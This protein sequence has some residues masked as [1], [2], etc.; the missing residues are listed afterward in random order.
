MSAVSEGRGLGVCFQ[1]LEGVTPPRG[2]VYI[3]G[4]I[5]W[6]GGR[7]SCSLCGLLA[8]GGQL[9]PLPQRCQPPCPQLLPVPLRAKGEEAESVG[10]PWCEPPLSVFLLLLTFLLL[11]KDAGWRSL[12]RIELRSGKLYTLGA[13][14]FTSAEWAPRQDLPGGSLGGSLE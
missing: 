6:S 7:L 2:A 1:G 3:V 5:I 13:S 12:R 9:I 14:A 4:R 11:P 10:Q 8:A